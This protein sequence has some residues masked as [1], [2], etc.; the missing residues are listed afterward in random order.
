MLLKRLGQSLPC[1][2]IHSRGL[3][4]LEIRNPFPFGV[5]SQHLR[6]IGVSREGR[7]YLQHG[8]LLY[9]THGSAFH[10]NGFD[11]CFGSDIS[12][13]YAKLVNHP[14]GMIPILLSVLQ[15]LPRRD[16]QGTPRR[17]GHRG[18][19]LYTWRISQKIP[20]GPSSRSF[21]APVRNFLIQSFIS[22]GHGLRLLTKRDASCMRIKS[23]NCN[24]S[25]WL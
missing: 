23:G 13:G 24:Q 1:S 17:S 14:F 6:S 9:G 18:A 15:K 2:T 3:L 12:R 21:V 16:M 7:C 20:L 8:L 22:S 11:A 4:F 10:Q 19:L 5:R 25:S